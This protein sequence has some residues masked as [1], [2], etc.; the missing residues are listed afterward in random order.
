LNLNVAGTHGDRW[1]GARR[2]N[3]PASRPPADPARTA[4][5]IEELRRANDRVRAL[6]DAVLLVSRDLDLPTVLRHVVSTAMELVGARY[7]A[8]GVLDEK[9]SGLAEFI[10]VGLTAQEYL[11]LAGIDFPRGRGLLGR[12]IRQPASIRVDE[13]AA[14]PD[15]AGFPPGH[16]PMHTML[17]VGIR[18]HGRVYGNIYLC[19]RA[20]GRPFD[21]DDEAVVEAL[22]CAAGVAVENARLFDEVRGGA[23][24]F[25]RLLL[26][27]LPDLAPLAVA[28][29]YRAS[30]ER[31]T[32][33]RQVGGDWYDA[34][35][36]SDGA[37]GAVVGDVVGHDLVAA[38][39]MAQ[40]RNMLRALLFGTR[41]PLS[42]VL[43]Q[44][45]RTLEAFDENPVTT[46]CLA[47]FEQ[48]GGEWTLRWSSAGHLPPLL[49]T[50]AGGSR[51]LG[52]DPDVPLGVEAGLPRHDDAVAL[53]A[54]ATVVFFTDG[55]V[56]HRSRPIDDG[57]SALAALAAAHADQ[58]LPTLCETLADKHPSDGHDDLAILALRVP[59]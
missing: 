39:A 9:G 19:D 13:I 40:T 18:V 47:R 21:E 57:L 52:S 20:D 31:G 1:T 28:A 7:G 35:R 54:G 58:P 16:P 50:P 51:Y 53:P 42:A 5:R 3:Q 15:S 24:Q 33:A 12:L 59:R 26:P 43:T 23:E 14:H 55:L 17:G 32:Q 38:A 27:R 25:Q 6:L 56:E 37:V 41:G 45:D 30:S 48:V 2:G 34:M 8:L 44:L 36:L 49:L 29:V 4:E 46:A 10:P 22:A 11:D